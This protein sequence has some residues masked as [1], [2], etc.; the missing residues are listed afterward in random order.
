MSRRE[1]GPIE[2][3]LGRPRA[4]YELNDKCSKLRAKLRGRDAPPALKGAFE[5]LDKLLGVNAAAIEWRYLNS[6]VHD[7]EIS[8]EFDRSV[9]RTIVE[10][11]TQLDQSLAELQ[12]RRD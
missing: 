11:L 1:F 5:A 6:G 10:A 3:K 12:P 7:A 9:V 2:L 4:P 8:H